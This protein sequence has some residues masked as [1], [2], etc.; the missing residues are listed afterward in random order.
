MKCG[1]YE[2]D[3]TPCIGSIIPGGFAARYVSE[4][5]DPLFARAFVAVTEEN[6]LA[7]VS[8][9]ACG[10]TKDITERI[11]QR[12]AKFSS[13]KPEHVMV[14][15][16]HAHGGGPTLNWGEEVVTEEHYIT[17]LVN[18]AAD[19][20][21][22]AWRKAE[23]SELLVG[24]AEVEG[25]SF[26]RIYRM[27]DGSYKTNPSR[28]EPEKIQEPYTSIDSELIVLC[29]KQENRPVGA[30]INF[31]THPATVA[32]T[33]VT[34]DYISVLSQELKKVY[35]SEFVTVF[36]NGA[37][38]NINHINPFDA[39]TCSGNRYRVVGSTLAEKAVE[40]VNKAVPMK[41]EVLLAAGK[42][43]AAH[44]RKPDA[45]D[46]K[47]A[48]EVF[49]EV[50]DNLIHAVPRTPNYQKVFFAL[51]AFRAMADKHTEK[52]LEL[53]LFQI[54]DVYIAGTP[55]QL[56]VE[57]GKAIKAGLAKTTM[58]SAFANDYC[59]YVPLDCFIGDAGVYEARL[60]PTST[61]A[62]G[63]GDKVVAG[64][65]ELQQEL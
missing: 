53:Q 9:D 31:A 13:I 37:C 59:G 23:T 27:K 14:M 20:I 35:G 2:T 33:Q 54:G 43:I 1:F 39:N 38:G 41:S 19:A 8:I 18:K 21:I 47:A 51:Q 7:V 26:I 62:K 61:L 48:K 56:F 34:G 12:V 16:T 46:L 49:E 11:R 6:A 28:K 42:Q 64:I 44:L 5:L 50:G 52:E 25:I 30:V 10:I 17:E 65:L 45:N 36:I 40:A 57:F 29:V 58:V 4:I 60:C 32:T 3:I 22:I 15:A 24:K 63:T 55:T